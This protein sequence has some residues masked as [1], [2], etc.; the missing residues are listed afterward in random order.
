VS[1][2]KIEAGYTAPVYLAGKLP[3]TELFTYIPF[4]CDGPGYLGWFYSGNGLKLY[5]EAYD[6]AG[7]NLK[8]FPFCFLAP[9]TAGWLKSD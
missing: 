2:G 1:T 4:G 5:Q 9:E 3:S 8:A 6:K 7:Y